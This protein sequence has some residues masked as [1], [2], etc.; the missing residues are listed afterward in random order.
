MSSFFSGI[1]S[2]LSGGI[3]NYFT[4]GNG[5]AGIGKSM[6]NAGD[7]AMDIGSQNMLGNLTAKY[8]GSRLTDAERE[9]NAFNA[10]EAEKNRA[11]QEQMSN[12]AFQRQVSDMRSAGLNPMLAAG[13]ASGASVPSGASASSVAPSSGDIGSLLSFFLQMKTFGLQKAL[14]SSEIAKN[15]AEKSNIEANTANVEAD[16]AAKNINNQWLEEYNRLRNAGMASQNELTYKQGREIDQRIENYKEELKKTVAETKESEER[17][18]LNVAQ[19]ILANVE[20]EN[21]KYLQPFIAAEKS[22]NSVAARASAQLSAVKA[23]Y[24]QGMIDNGAIEA[25]I[26]AQNANASESEIQAEMKR[27]NQSIRDGSAP[28]NSASEKVAMALYQGLTLL[29]GSVMG[30][31]NN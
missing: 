6:S 22:A 25:A 1:L 8:T 30:K 29:S 7:T 18:R 24:E 17:A 28:V 2:L 23:A 11:W 5:F 10:G 3:S 31:M 15:L 14:T 19:A 12:T 4:N 9:A 16:T 13:S 21:I 26:R 20:A 27:F